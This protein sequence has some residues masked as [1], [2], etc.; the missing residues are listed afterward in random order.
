MKKLYAILLLA[1]TPL[2]MAQTPLL[3][4]N[5]DYTEAS[6]L[7]ANGWGAHSA[8]AT[9]PI[10]VTAPGLTFAN[11]YGSAIGNAAGVNNTGQDINR[12]FAEAT[13]GSV[14]TSFLVNATA[15]TADEYFFLLGANP[16]TTAFRG[17]VF[18]QPNTTDATKF[19]V[20][21]SFNA[22]TAQAT[23]AT[24]YNFG[25]TY[26]FVLKY[27]IVDGADNDTVS[28]FVFPIADSFITEPATPT[29][30]PLAGTAADLNPGT[31]G[32]R[33]FNATQRITVDGIRV[34]TQW[35]V[36][37]GTAGVG[38]HNRTAIKTYPNPVN[39]GILNVSAEGSKTL[40]IYDLT[41]K[42]VF[43]AET[44]NSFFDVS[45]LQNGMY[46]ARIN[47]GNA[48]LNQKLIINK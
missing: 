27:T 29:L 15:S 11:Y 3:V 20:G 39:A 10:L 5:F 6:A 9:N 37:N 16:I 1:Q 32:L 7:T 2:L 33:Q 12:G 40:T 38:E 26:L 30:G 47:A 46:I 19:A 17:R 13:T 18:L 23:T 21:F 22:S 42:Q 4:E 25:E 44:Q 45:S 14:Y 41:G 36:Y 48:T 43:A 8:A 24:L 28:L 31:V 35:D 34:S